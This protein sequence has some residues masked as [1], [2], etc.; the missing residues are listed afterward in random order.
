MKTS[1][2]FKGLQ[3]IIVKQEM[4]GLAT[5]GIF[6]SG[7]VLNSICKYSFLVCFS[8]I[9]DSSGVNWKNI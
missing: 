6:Y 1:K 4:L 7:L 5:S 2:D 3:I 8:V 9:A